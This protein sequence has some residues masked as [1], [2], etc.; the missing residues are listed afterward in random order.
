MGERGP[1]RPPR[2]ARPRAPRGCAG[3]HA[4]PAAPAPNP[5]IPG[6]PR[7]QTAAGSSTGA[8]PHTAARGHAA[9]LPAPVRTPRMHAARRD[10]HAVAP[11]TAQAV[12]LDP[13]PPL[14]RWPRAATPAGRGGRE[15]AT[16][17]RRG[18]CGARIPPAAALAWGARGWLGPPAPQPQAV[19]P[20]FAAPSRTSAASAPPTTPCQAL[21]RTR[22]PARLPGRPTW[23]Q[24]GTWAAA[25]RCRGGRLRL[26]PG[27]LGAGA[28]M[29]AMWAIAQQVR[30]RDRLQQ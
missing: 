22:R 2:R 1:R 29:W 14:A 8:A 5:T 30:E 25:R 26:R 21:P 27:M 3:A 9:A 12:R 6:T 7:R 19:P 28:A 11:P 16:G 13:S 23:L 20:T 17:Q 10:G 4:G 24:P 15:P 18:S